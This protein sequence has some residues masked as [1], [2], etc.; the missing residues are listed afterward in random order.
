MAGCDAETE[1]KKT[2]ATVAKQDRGTSAEPGNRV[3]DIS[4]LQ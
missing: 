3:L 2:M 4:W 1:K